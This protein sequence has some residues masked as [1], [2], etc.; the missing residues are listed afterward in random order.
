[1]AERVRAAVE[2]TPFMVA[3]GKTGVPVTVSAGLAFLHPDETGASLI[4][5]ADAAL[6]AS[7][8]GGRNMVTLAEAA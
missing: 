3:G 5:R 6:Y 7:K 2:S 1:V 8:T 4:S